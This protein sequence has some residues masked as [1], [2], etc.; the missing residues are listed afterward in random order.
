LIGKVGEHTAID[1]P[2]NEIES[3]EMSIRVHLTILMTLLCLTKPNVN[4]AFALDLLQ[5]GTTVH[6]EEAERTRLKQEANNLA[7]QAYN[8]YKELRYDSA[9]E[10]LKQAEII[11]LQL[12]P[13][14]TFPQGHPDLV[15]VLNNKAAILN[16]QG[17]YERARIVF[18]QVLAMDR[19]L[20]PED[21]FPQGH[22][23]LASSL[24]NLGAVANAQGDHRQAREYREQALAMYQR[25]YPKNKFPRGHPKVALAGNNLGFVLYSQGDYERARKYYEQAL[26]MYRRLY[27]EAQFP[28][29]HPRIGLSLNNLGVLFTEQGEYQRAAEVYGQALPMYEHFYSKEKFPHGHPRLTM[30]LNNLGGVFKEQKEYSRSKEYFSK[31]L[32]MNK[33]LYPIEDYPHGHP[34]MALSLNNLGFLADAQGAYGEAAAY[35]GQS[36]NMY[37]RLYP[38]AKCPAGHPDLA[39]ALSNLAAVLNSLG[40]DAQS[41]RL[42]E[43]ALAM[44]ERLYPASVYPQGHPDLAISLNNLGFMSAVLRRYS[45]SAR[46]LK[47]AARMKNDLG[48]FFIAGSSEAEALNFAARHLSAP[49]LLL[50][51]WQHAGGPDEELYDFLWRRKGLIFRLMAGRQ[52]AFLELKN[53]GLQKL[54][55]Q[56][57]DT[58]QK[59]ARL[60]LAP[61]DPDP[62]RSSQVHGSLVQLTEQKEVL[63]RQLAATIPE[64][65]DRIQQQRGSLADLRSRLPRAAVLIDLLEYVHMEWDTEMRTRAGQ[66]RT[67]SYVAFVVCPRHPVVRVD[68]GPAEPIDKAITTWRK[69]IARGG[70]E[71]AAMVLSTLLWQP[72]RKRLPKDTKTVLICPDGATAAIPWGALPGCQKDTILLEEYTIALIPHPQFLLERRK[73]LGVDEGLILAAGDVDYDRKPK[74]VSPAGPLMTREAVRGEMLVRWNL[75]PGTR[76][77]LEEIGEI[78]GKQQMLRLDHAEA[79]A[80]RILSELPNTRWA[81]FATHGFFADPEFRSALRLDKRAFEERE[82][83]GSQE[84]ITVGARN[85]LVLSGLVFAGANLPREADELGIPQ[86]DG[87]ILTA[88]AIEGLPLGNLELAVL[89]ACETG[90]GDVAGGEGVFGLQ[91]AFHMAGAHIVVASLWKVDDQATAALM[92]L[93]YEQLWRKKKPP[94]A[95]LREAQLLLYRHPALITTL[96]KRGV[97]M[98]ESADTGEGRRQEATAATRLWASFTVSG[99][100]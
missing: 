82:L 22:E 42:F 25:L 21:Q 83:S 34:E 50:S 47:R 7:V 32:A 66:R 41:W 11:L 73:S 24:N 23:E 51:V 56:Y 92:K 43:R 80:S 100:E 19:K 74:E 3:K 27:P 96:G 14:N 45:K 58:R 2:A 1:Q 29:G 38:A 9:L 81:H 13:P 54:Y 52:K 85:P 55:Q 68:L 44:R 40:R 46:M 48:E 94:L 35:F 4:S 86:G 69:E 65:R 60:M 95:A 76:L 70:N 15:F 53:P 31:A 79:S 26:A 88:E 71:A 98:A 36:L 87:G 8:L 28:H 33:R 75:L 61:T 37:E 30:I 5:S 78:I 12:Y 99:I 57:L 91:R 64:F 67:R 97:T 89:S 77:E 62:K 63:E 10:L 72:L 17:D 39:M 84:R 6:S 20:Y 59:L 93:F 49:S 18:E 16:D 90:L